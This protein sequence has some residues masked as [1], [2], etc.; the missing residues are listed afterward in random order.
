MH[1]IV[2]FFLW[3]RMRFDKIVIFTPIE[4]IAEMSVLHRM[5]I[6]PFLPIIKSIFDNVLFDTFVMQESI[7]YL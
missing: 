7:V 3:V 1:V 4:A 6:G 5:I 2:F